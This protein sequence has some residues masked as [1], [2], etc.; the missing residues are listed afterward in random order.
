MTQRTE[1]DPEAFGNNWADRQETYYLHWTRGEPKNQ[2]QLAFRQLWLLFNHIMENDFQGRRVL[3]VGCGRGSMSAYF[4]DAGYDSTLLDISPHVVETAYEVFARHGLKARFSVG[5]AL[6]LPYDDNSF[7]I[8][9]SIGLLEHFED[10]EAVIREQARVLATGGLFFGYVV[11]ENKDNIQKDYEWINDLLRAIVPADQVKSAQQKEEVYRSDAMS[12]RYL[13]VMRKL[14][15]RNI[16]ASGVYPLPMI[17]FSPEFPFTL[18][19]DAAEA[20]LV[21]HFSKILADREPSLYGPY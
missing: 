20:V 18:L 11:P 7:D 19:N 8:V 10:I 3:E 4:A 12:R 5:D 1:G 9:F 14:P 15:F 17:S 13:G 6:S 16:S 2:I 21:R